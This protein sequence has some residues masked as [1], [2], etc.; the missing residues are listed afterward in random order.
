MRCCSKI[1]DYRNTIR[2]ILAKAMKIISKINTLSEFRVGMGIA[3]KRRN[4][5]LTPTEKEK[6]HVSHY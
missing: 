6:R 2:L 3:F 5:G 4:R 1:C